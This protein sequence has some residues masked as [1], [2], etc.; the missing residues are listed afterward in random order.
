MATGATGRSRAALSV[1][2][3]ALLT[4]MA[5][6]AG[7]QDSSP[8]I[9]DNSFFIEEAYNQEA[10]VVQHISNLVH[11]HTG[12]VRSDYSFTQ[13]WPVGGQAHQFSYT[14]PYEWA[15]R[16]ATGIGD[17]LLNYRYQ[18]AGHDAWAA[19]APRLSLVVPTGG[20]GGAGS[21]GYQLNLPASRRMSPG[22]VMHANAG[23]TFFP[24][25]GGRFFNVGASVVALVRPCFNPMLEVVLTHGR[26]REDSGLFATKTEAIVSPGVRWAINRGDLQIVPGLGLPVRFGADGTK[27]GAFLYLSFEHS[28]TRAAAAA[29]RGE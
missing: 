25:S 19:V 23:A 11:I 12:D 26:D 13:E 21:T 22:L 7:S 4:L 24:R 18:L 3:L 10:G 5:G 15:R 16:S 17:V 20:H 8:P 1:F 2:V 29:R 14:V 28:F 6:A 27:I 9:E